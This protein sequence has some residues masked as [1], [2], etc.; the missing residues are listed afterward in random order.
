MNE[1]DSVPNYSSSQ[2]KEIS[3]DDWRFGKW[4]HGRRLPTPGRWQ[5]MN[6]EI[7]RK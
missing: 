6:M 4:W 7:Y 3:A 2:S 1:A 5:S